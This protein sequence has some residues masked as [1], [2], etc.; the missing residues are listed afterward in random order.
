M[1]NVAQQRNIARQELDALRKAKQV[2]KMSEF[3]DEL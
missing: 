1:D 3:G 2:I